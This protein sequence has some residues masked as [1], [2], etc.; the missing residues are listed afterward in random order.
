MFTCSFVVPRTLDASPRPQP[1]PRELDARRKRAADHARGE[2]DEATGPLFM[3]G[4]VVYYILPKSAESVQPRFNQALWKS[5]GKATTFRPPVKRLHK[6]VFFIFRIMC[7]RMLFVRRL[8]WERNG[9]RLRERSLAARSTPSKA[10]SRWESWWCTLTAFVAVFVSATCCQDVH[11]FGSRNFIVHA[12]AG[13]QDRLCPRGAMWVESPIL[14]AVSPPPRFWPNDEAGV[15]KYRWRLF[16]SLSGQ[17]LLMERDMDRQAGLQQRR[18][19]KGPPVGRQPATPNVRECDRS[20]GQPNPTCSNPESTVNLIS[21]ATFRFWAESNRC[22]WCCEP[23]RLRNLRAI[24]MYPSSLWWNVGIPRDWAPR[25][26]VDWL[27]LLFAHG[28]IPGVE[29]ASWVSLS[30]HVSNLADEVRA[31]RRS[32]T[33]PSFECT[34]LFP[35]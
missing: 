19:G 34:S 29:S 26:G 17:T 18:S 5:G 6:K 8:D 2:T 16:P 13:T 27:P 31:A 10:G 11:R 14:P 25:A 22:R 9:P 4:F 20:A 1:T 15:Q 32:T 12:R 35:R 30:L 7:V 24:F 28:R 21:P 33:P 3:G 23:P